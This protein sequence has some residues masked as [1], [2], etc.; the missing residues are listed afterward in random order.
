MI[1]LVII[2]IVFFPLIQ[3]LSRGLL[4]SS[5]TKNTSIA[6]SLARDKLEKIKNL[7]FA[8]IE[9]ETKSAVP[10]FSNFERAVTVNSLHSKLKDTEVKVYWQS[11]D[12]SELYLS[13]KTLISS[14][15]KI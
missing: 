9:P 15:M 12:G 13:L 11:P 1:T 6:L 14:Y 5:E 4:V 3:M 7:D 10:D 2:V 8:S